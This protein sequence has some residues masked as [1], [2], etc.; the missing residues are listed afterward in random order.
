[1]SGGAKTA[2]F[3]LRIKSIG[4]LCPSCVSGRRLCDPE[5][6]SPHACH[7]MRVL[8]TAVILA[9]LIKP[10]CQWCFRRDT[11]THLYKGIVGST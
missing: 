11:G 5:P 3:V 1:M 2:C 7:I 10:G 6:T 9:Y 8:C 4:D